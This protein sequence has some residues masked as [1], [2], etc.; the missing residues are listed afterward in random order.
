MYGSD[1]G[2]AIMGA[3]VVFGTTGIAIVTLHACA[4]GKLIGHVVLVVVV[5]V[6]VSTKIAISRNVDI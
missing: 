4:T 3:D 2:S 1:T 5:V 6:V